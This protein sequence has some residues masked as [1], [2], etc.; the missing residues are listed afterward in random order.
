MLDGPG[1]M[2]K[3]VDEMRSVFDGNIVIGRDLMEIP[4]DI[5]Y[6]HRID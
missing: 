5:K 6:P 1:I 2:E 3:L 4:L